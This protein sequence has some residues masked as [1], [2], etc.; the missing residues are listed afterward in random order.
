MAVATET[1]TPVATRNDL[2]EPLR[3][4]VIELLSIPLA[5]A[6]DLQTQAKQAH[7][8]VKGPSFFAL[9]EL[10]DRVAAEAGTYADLLAE[11]VVQLG[12][13]A[14]GTARAVAARSGLPEYPLDILSGVDHVRAL[15]AALASFGARVRRAI[16]AATLVGDQGSADIFTE[17]SRGSDK[18]LW[19]VEAHG[20]AGE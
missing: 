20:H 10:F 11:R 7:W 15:S 17:I 12:G 6:I 8:N 19:F 18:L 1:T 9:H 14:A 2:P 3:S 16:D 5:D 13:V 4:D